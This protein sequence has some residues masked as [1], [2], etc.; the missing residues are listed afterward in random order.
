MQET[1]GEPEALNF[2]GGSSKTNYDKPRG[3]E[4][5]VASALLY[6]R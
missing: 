3:A 6:D 1:S 4:K 5:T 2:K